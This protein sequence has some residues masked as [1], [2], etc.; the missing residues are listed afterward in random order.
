MFAN[1]NYFVLTFSSLFFVSFAFAQIA[2][3]PGRGVSGSL[4]RQPPPEQISITA[5]PQNPQREDKGPLTSRKDK[6]LIEPDAADMA[7]FQEL[8]NKSGYGIVKLLNSKC[9]AEAENEYLISATEGCANSLPGNG[10]YFS[11]RRREHSLPAYADIKIKNDKFIVGSFFTQGLIASLGETELEKIELDMA[12]IKY[13][14][15]FSPAKDRNGAKTQTS[16]IDRG[17]S[18]EGYLYSELAKIKENQAYVLRSIA[19]RTDGETGDKRRDVIIAFQVV[20]QDEDGNVTLIWK[21][22]Q[23]K[24]SPKLYQGK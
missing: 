13:L 2:A 8:L 15:N 19:Y 14:A 22:L 23:N 6:R 7:K 24:E 21:E 17:L 3:P 9:S 20:R 12:G 1:T 10:A 4:I 18:D 16:E 5:I 11:F